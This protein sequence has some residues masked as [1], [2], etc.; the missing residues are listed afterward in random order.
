MALLGWLW[1]KNNLA[2]MGWKPENWHFSYP[3]ALC[4][5]PATPA[6]HA[7]LQAG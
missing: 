2:G 1:A 6:G 4:P 3:A 7:P 5:Y